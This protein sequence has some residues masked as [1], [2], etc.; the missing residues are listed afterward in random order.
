MNTKTIE[1]R[2]WSK[3]NKTTNTQEC[4][5]W[6]GAR[7]SKFGYGA[8]KY[9]KKTFNAHRLSFIINNPDIHLSV[10]DFI[11][12]S[13]DNPKC[14]NPNHLFL[15]NNSLNMKDAYTKNRIVIPTRRRYVK[16]HIP[17]NNSI[18]KELLE[19]ILTEYETKENTLKFLSTKYKVSYQALKDAR[20]SKNSPPPLTN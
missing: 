18:T 7:R 5:E 3:V 19:Q 10:K 6:L 2:F 8:I 9:N 20:R 16:G 14:V 13:C 4:W 11:C 15:G 1:E 17:I 12:H